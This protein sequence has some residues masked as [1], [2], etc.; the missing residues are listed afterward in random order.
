MKEALTAKKI[1]WEV[2][3]DIGY[4]NFIDAP[5]NRMDTLF[6]QELQMLTTDTIPKSKIVAI[7]ISGSG[8][9]FSSGANLD[10]LFHEIENEKR[11]SSVLIANHH[12]LKFLN[13]LNIPVIAAIKGVCLG[14]ALELALHCH[15]RLC[16]NDAIFGLPESSFGLIPGLGGIPKLRQLAGKAKALESLQEE[17]DR[18]EKLGLRIIT[19]PQPGEA[20][21]NK[22][23]AFVFGKYGLNIELSFLSRSSAMFSL[24]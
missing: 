24:I 16:S 7:I 9:H 14:S 21:N 15:F 20:F 18:L 22:D 17:L 1:S 8:R 4:L 12:S 13:D 10:D 23:I 3:D 19:K 2:R 5:E 11:E 6:F